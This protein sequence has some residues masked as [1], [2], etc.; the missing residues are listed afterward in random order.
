MTYAY[1]F[2]VKTDMNL[3]VR[4]EKTMRDNNLKKELNSAICFLIVITV[5]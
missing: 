2:E 5:F 1:M 4:C 3:C